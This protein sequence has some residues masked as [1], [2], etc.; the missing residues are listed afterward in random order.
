MKIKLSTLYKT[1]NEASYLNNTEILSLWQSAD[2]AH[3]A[4]KSVGAD[5]VTRRGIFELESRLHDVIRLR[6]IASEATNFATEAQRRQEVLE[7]LAAASACVE[8]AIDPVP[9]IERLEL[10]Q[11]ALNVLTTDG[12]LPGFVGQIIDIIRPLV[13]TATAGLR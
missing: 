13:P 1:W 12:I 5:W 3:S 11:D 2:A 7:L 9:V 10:G 8:P 6:G 4:L